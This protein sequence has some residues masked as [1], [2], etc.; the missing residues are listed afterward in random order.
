MSR[1]RRQDDV[2]GSGDTRNTQVRD[3]LSY[4]RMFKIKIEIISPRKRKEL[5]LD[6]A[7]QTPS[8]YEAV[9]QQ[10]REIKYQRKRYKMWQCYRDGLSIT[11]Y[12]SPQTTQQQRK[13]EKMLECRRKEHLFKDICFPAKKKKCRRCG[14][15]G[16]FSKV[17]R[18]KNSQPTRAFSVKWINFARMLGI[19]SA[20]ENEL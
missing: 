19:N 16:H 1:L 11:L 9:A 17:F 15:I 7:L 6:V 18:S 14:R 3:Q 20:R 13:C 12:Y 8:C 10:V 4:R 2:C 5:S